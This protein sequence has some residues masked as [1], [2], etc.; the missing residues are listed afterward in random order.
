MFI[1]IC[2]GITERQIRNA[3]QEGACTVHDLRACLGVGAGC[4][5]CA[6]FAADML[7]EAQQA[8]P[9]ARETSIAA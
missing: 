3:I 1:C 4:G 2:N 8:A 7:S 6:E 5:C 9:S